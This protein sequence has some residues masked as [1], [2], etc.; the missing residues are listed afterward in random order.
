MGSGPIA[1]DHLLMHSITSFLTKLYLSDK[2]NSNGTRHFFIYYLI[3]E[4][5]ASASAPIN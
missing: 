1:S 4:P 2:L 3:G 5:R